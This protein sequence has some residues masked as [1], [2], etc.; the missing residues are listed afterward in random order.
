MMTLTAIQHG[1]LRTIAQNPRRHIDHQLLGWAQQL[2]IKNAGKI[3]LVRAAVAAGQLEQRGLL[4][5]ER[6]LSKPDRL[7]WSVTPEGEKFLD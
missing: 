3:D 2:I 5:Y 7:L 4:R 6:D 1:V